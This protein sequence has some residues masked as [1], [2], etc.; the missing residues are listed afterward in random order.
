M[1]LKR[2]L[3]GIVAVTVT[4][5]AVYAASTT[6]ANL[7]PATSLSGSEY[8]AIDQSTGGGNYT[9]RRAAVSQMVAL[10][11]S[12]FLSSANNLSDL[13]SPSTARTNLGLGTL[14][15]QNSVAASQLPAPTASTL[16]GVQSGTAST[17][18]FQTG[19]STSGGLTFAQPT[20]SNI[21][22]LAPS[23]T[24]DTTNA[25]NVTSGTLGAARLPA[26][27]GDASSTAGAATL[28]LATVNASPGSVGSSTAIPVLTTNAKGL[29]TGQSTAAVV[30]PAGTLT[31]A[32]LPANV[33]SSFLTGVGTI[34][35]GTWQGTLVGPTYGGTGVNN[36]SNTL[37]VPATGTAALLGT[38]QTITAAKTFTNSDLLLLG[39]STGT[40]T[41][42]SA[43]ASATN[44]TATVPANTGTLAELN[45]AQTFTQPQTLAGNA[46]SSAGQNAGYIGEVLSASASS[47]AIT[48]STTTNVASLSV[49]TGHW[50]CW[51]WIT[52]APGAT[53]VQ[54]EEIGGLSLS[55][56]AISPGVGAIEMGA[57]LTAGVAFNMEFGPVAY[58]FT[59]PTTVYNNQ[60]ITYSV[61]T[62]TTGGGIQ[63]Q[64]TW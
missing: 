14:A 7:P 63:C 62:L 32:G 17:N 31:G 39:S 37:T 10:V 33:L 4:G 53:T 29:V 58:N 54:S 55:S 60:Y 35:T 47:V 43:N 34:G 26:F 56:S 20:A 1:K 61:S 27:S 57:T 40:T 13:L 22:G 3:A 9:T 51:G 36:G 30:A 11:G 48:A 46:S 42:A 45:L 52:T 23:A 25:S 15:I 44:Y 18:Q 41:F 59:S 64:R 21:S 24:T 12:A 5:A 38:A 49:T 28:T 16:G 8:V 6:I 19:I 50:L 2:L